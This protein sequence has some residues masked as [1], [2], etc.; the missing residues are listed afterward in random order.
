MNRQS[1]LISDSLLSSL[2]AIGSGSCKDSSLVA[3]TRLVSRSS[4]LNT[5]SSKVHSDATDV[6]KMG[7]DIQCNAKV[8]QSRSMGC[9]SNSCLLP[10]PQL[11]KLV[12][13]VPNST[14]PS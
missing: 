9:T 13:E 1:H 11:G 6:G 7:A 4:K 5:A 2:L 3:F 8:I 14:I 10:G 12:A